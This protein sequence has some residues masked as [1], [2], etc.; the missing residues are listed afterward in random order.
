MRRNT[1][2]HPN[3]CEA[4]ADSEDVVNLSFTVPRATFNSLRVLCE[5]TEN[6]SKAEI[7]EAFCWVLQKLQRRENSYYEWVTNPSRR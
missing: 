1:R 6:P 5:L 3:H 7:S 2:N 4:S